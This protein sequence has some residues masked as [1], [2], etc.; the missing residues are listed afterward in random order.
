MQI[1]ICPETRLAL[2]SV[3]LFLLA[4]RPGAGKE[5]TGD[6]I[7]AIMPNARRIVA[8][9]EIDREV[10]TGSSIGAEMQVY[11]DAH[12][13]VPDTLVIPFLFAR[14]R[15]LYMEGCSEIIGDGFPR[16]EPQ[17][18]LIIG[19]ARHFM[20]CYLDIDEDL[21]IQRM[22]DRGR[23]GETRDKCIKRH[24]DFD[25]LTLPMVK[26]FEQKHPTRFMK[27]D[28]G[29]HEARNRAEQAIARMREMRA[30]AA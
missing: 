29:R 23:A 2:D 17:D 4:G 10:Q 8:S 18:R 28:S 12:E 16:T 9:E 3:A 14:I 7:L 19:N 13:I 26:A 5:K 27:I 30:V 11:K 24:R 1:G 22:L 25:R 6:E 15:Q 21:A 20:M